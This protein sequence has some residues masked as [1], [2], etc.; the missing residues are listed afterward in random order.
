MEVTSEVE[1]NV[2]I[3]SDALESRREFFRAK[4]VTVGHVFVLVM[5]MDVCVGHDDG[6]V[7]WS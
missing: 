7:C 6:C 4:N 3:V 1:V 2:V 5:M